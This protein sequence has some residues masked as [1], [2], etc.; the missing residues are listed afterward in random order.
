LTKPRYT[1][2]AKIDAVITAMRDTA[3]RNELIS[4]KWLEASQH[5][6]VLRAALQS[7]MGR[8]IN[9][10]KIG[11]WLTKHLG[12]QCNGYVLRGRHART[13]EDIWYWSIWHSDDD[14]LAAQEAAAIEREAVAAAQEKAWRDAEAVRLRGVRDLGRVHRRLT[15]C[16]DL[17]GEEAAKQALFQG[18]GV[19][20]LADL[21]PDRYRS[22]A[23][24][25]KAA[26]TFAAIKA[27]R[28][29]FEA[30]RAKPDN[31]PAMVE[32]P[33]FNTG[34]TVHR[35]NR[36]GQLYNPMQ[37]NGV[38]ADVVVGANGTRAPR[39]HQHNWFGWNTW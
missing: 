16:R 13:T 34:P 12:S 4:A 31:K 1:A 10:R 8:G 22:V 38:Q 26:H 27:K 11:H 15:V 35:Y 29:L 14:K 24:A 36:D 32:G 21:A 39:N 30:A 18:G 3:G 37:G 9:A 28:E 20:N 25:C 6:T 7:A 23:D 33:Q 17:Y 5:D 2:P 19:H